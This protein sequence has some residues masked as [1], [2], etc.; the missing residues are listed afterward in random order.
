VGTVEERARHLREECA[1]SEVACS[2]E[3][4]DTKV[5]RFKLAGHEAS[6]EHREVSCDK[7]NQRVNA[8]EMD[9]HLLGCALAEVECPQEC[10][11]R[12]LRGDLGEH[13]K[14]CEN[15]VVSCPFA[16]HGCSERGKRKR[17]VEHEE[18]AAV[19]HSRLAARRAGREQERVAKLESEL[20]QVVAELEESK[21]RVT[22]LD[23]Q[24]SVALQM[25]GG[26]SYGEAKV[27]WRV[28]DFTA[29]AIEKRNLVSKV[30][31]V[32]TTAGE[33][34]LR[35]LLVFRR[36]AG[37]TEHGYVGL[38]VKHTSEDGGSKNFPVD[39]AG[40]ELTVIKGATKE[41]KKFGDHVQLINVDC[42]RGRF[43]LMSTDKIR[44]LRWTDQDPEAVSIRKEP[45]YDVTD[46]LEDGTLTVKGYIR[47]T[48][49]EAEVEI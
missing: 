35:L 3:G 11:A 14:E 30:F 44:G 42:Y 37:C 45:E 20:T 2:C 4:C 32:Q 7:C 19:A 40:A 17:I 39:L 41:T 15:V 31:H 24:L 8:G 33:Y 46:F 12:V 25:R 34:H 49:P 22:A 47:I 10:G 38:F 27:T 6:C 36:K 43:K 26:Q 1:Y 9:E 21:R 48:P 5:V 23:R 13:E 16:E 28:E 18:E 29:K